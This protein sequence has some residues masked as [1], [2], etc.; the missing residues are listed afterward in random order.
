MLRSSPPLCET[1]DLVML[2]L[3]GVVY[4]GAEAVP[5][6][7]FHLTKVREQGAH[8]AFITN[9]ASRPP[10]AVATHLS[11]LGI[12]T[13][14]GEVVTSAQA[15]ARLAS[16]RV[17]PGARVFLLGGDGVRDALEEHGL[18]PVQEHDPRPELVVSGYAPDLP[19]RTIMTGAMLVRDGV[20]WIASNTD[21]TV[22]TAAGLGPGHGVLVDMVERFA[23]VTATVAGKPA[24]P[25]LDETMIRVGGERPLMVGDRLDTDIAGARATGVP[26]LLVL[27][28][29]TDLAAL[30]E[31]A[32]DE[33]PSYLA[34]DLGGLLEAHPPVALEGTTA[35]VGGWRVAVGE[36][37]VD[38]R[39]EG[40]P[41]DWW[42]AL[43]V[44]AWAHLDRTGAPVAVDGVVPPASR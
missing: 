12:P 15:A 30:V 20:P 17:G 27:T 38:V 33:R 10:A 4:V 35:T 34:P 18:V 25:L 14:P 32:A 39:G 36:T 8:L 21:T 9:N 29:V 28:G 43:A 37:G 41:A 13:D 11:R 5:G 3:D 7:A 44:A 40:A 26:S 31:A 22:P 24:R 6:A 19:W 23:G 2:D 16:G 42:R 1:H